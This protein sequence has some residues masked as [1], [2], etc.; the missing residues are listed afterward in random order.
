MIFY[1]FANLNILILVSQQSEQRFLSDL[2]IELQCLSHKFA[3]DIS[4]VLHCLEERREY[5]IL[6]LD[7]IY[8]SE[9]LL[10][11]LRHMCPRLMIIFITDD[12]MPTSISS[13]LIRFILRPPSMESIQICFQDFINPNNKQLYTFH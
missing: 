3:F 2:L 13:N 9:S 10:T 4:H 12:H 1:S 8:E 5:H 6:F 11:R 7:R